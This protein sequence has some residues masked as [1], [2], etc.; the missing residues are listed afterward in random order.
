MS[1]LMAA[2]DLGRMNARDVSMLTYLLTASYDFDQPLK[3]HSNDYLSI[4]YGA[5]VYKKTAV[6]FFYLTIFRRGIV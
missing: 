6:V 5:N 1:K 4:N 2:I 3:C